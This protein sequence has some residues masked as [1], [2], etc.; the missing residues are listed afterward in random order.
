MKSLL[1]IFICVFVLTLNKAQANLPGLSSA[2]VRHLQKTRGQIVAQKLLLGPTPKTCHSQLLNISADN[3]IK[4]MMAFGYMDVSSGQQ[5]K[6][7]ATHLYGKGNVLDKDA[8]VAMEH[9]LL[10]SCHKKSTFACGFRQ[11]GSVFTK[12][13]RNRFTGKRMKVEITLVSPAVS[14][15]DSQNQNQL[16][17]KQERSSA[18]V[19]AKF[20]QSFS[21]A[22]AVIYMGHARSGGGPDFFPPVLTSGGRV[23][24]SYYKSQQEGIRSMVSALQ[25]SSQIPL[26]G[27]LACKSTGLFSKR[28]RRASPGTVFVTADALFDYNDILPTGYAMLEAIVGQRCSDSFEDIVRIQPASSRFLK[29]FF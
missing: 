13:I 6:D 7:S 26:V 2:Y 21:K 18:N 16:A 27:V 20:L 8:R 11:R 17:S 10:S 19:R 22:D 25:T 28:I 9:M 4:I 23:N 14:S 3:K 29:V 5:F 24:Y 12:K 15:S 1:T